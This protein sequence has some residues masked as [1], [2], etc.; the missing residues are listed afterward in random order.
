MQRQ[1]NE[2][3]RQRRDFFSPFTTLIMFDEKHFR[4]NAN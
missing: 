2:N 3:V 4:M 1:K